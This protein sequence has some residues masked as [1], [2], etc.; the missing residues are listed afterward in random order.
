MQQMVI[1]SLTDY[2]DAVQGWINS[3]CAWL[4]RCTN[5]SA[6]AAAA[7]DAAGFSTDVS[8]TAGRVWWSSACH[9]KTSH[10]TTATRCWPSSCNLVQRSST[11][12]VSMFVFIC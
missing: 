1:V 2:N 7:H 4:A 3:C 10:G 6:A 12:T 11:T 8:A 9:T 5:V